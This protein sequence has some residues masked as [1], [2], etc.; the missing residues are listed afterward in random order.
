MR[1]RKKFGGKDVVWNCIGTIFSMGISFLMLPFLLT[2]LNS[3]QLGIWYVMVSFSNLASLFSLGFTPAFARNVAY[4]W[5]GAK[6]LSKTGKEDT[7]DSNSVDYHL[8][9]T[10]LITSRYLYLVFAVIGTL[11]IGLFGTLHIWR[12]AGSFL[13][14]QTKM[15]WWIFLI[16]I[17]LNIYYGYFSSYLVGIGCV[18]ESNQI[19]VAA[20]ITRIVVMALTMYLGAGIFGAALSYLINGLILRISGKLMFRHETMGQR[21][22]GGQAEKITF[23]EMKACFQIVW[24][25]AWRD[26]I[27]SVSDYLSTQ[28]G[29][30][31]CSSYLSLADTAKYSLTAQL[32]TAIGKIA[33]SIHGAYTPVLQRS[34]ITGDQKTARETQGFGVFCFII[35]YLLG[36]AGLLT[37]GKFVLDIIKP[38]T[39]LDSYLIFI[40]GIYQFMLSYRNCYGVYL[41][42]TNR[43]WYWK[44]YIITSFASVFLYS[45]L[46]ALAG[47]DVKWIIYASILCEAT[48]NFWKWPRLVNCELGL[49]LR[50]IFC[51]GISRIRHL[52]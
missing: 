12:I 40:Y 20:G 16:A 39:K 6:K 51:L 41:S 15:G 42:C 4:C 30:I 49:T 1:K 10:V 35:V 2:F 27:V 43:L 29:T 9:M 25:N 21:F 32:V 8:L 14:L 50:N 13:T 52:R 48:Y 24:Y 18:K 22:D 44:S 3:G 33:K 11:T 38:D 36:M 34:Y 19:T 31:V 28:M 7:A 46:L 23:K 17:F 47:A 26:G 45:V 5:N 37:V